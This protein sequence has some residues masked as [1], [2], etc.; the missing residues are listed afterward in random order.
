MGMSQILWLQV[1]YRNLEI[2]PLRSHV[3]QKS[4][5]FVKSV[6]GTEVHGVG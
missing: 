5:L 3:F 2:G 4:S 6:D 1:S